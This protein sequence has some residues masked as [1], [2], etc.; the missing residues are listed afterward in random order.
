M[1]NTLSLSGRTILIAVAASQVL[2]IF[3]PY[4]KVEIDFLCHAGGMA[5]G[6][7]Y[8]RW[9]RDNGVKKEKPENK[10]LTRMGGW[11]DGVLGKGR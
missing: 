10:A 9:W 5:V 8:A 4:G 3:R 6:Y 1:T 11:W 2:G 7:A